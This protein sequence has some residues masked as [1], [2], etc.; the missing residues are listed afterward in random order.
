MSTSIGVFWPNAWVQI[1]LETSYWT[2]FECS[3]LYTIEI[4]NWSWIIHLY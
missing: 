1:G 2:R 3:D 4:E